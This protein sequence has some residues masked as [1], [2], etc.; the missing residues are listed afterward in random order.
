MILPVASSTSSSHRYVKTVAIIPAYNEEG[1]IGDVVRAV[2]K[3]VDRVI[4]VNDGSR[5]GTAAVAAAEGAIVISHGL[6]CGAGA[7]TMTGIVAARSLGAECAVTIDADGQHN[8][9]DI[10][11]LLA[12]VLRGETDITI[13][14]RFLRANTIPFIRRVFNAIGN[15]LTLITTGMY[16]SDSQSGF[17]CLGPAALRTI[18]LHLNGFEFCTEIIREA[19]RHQ[20]RIAEIPIRVTYSEYTLAKGQSFAGGVRTACKIL[21]RTFLR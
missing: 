10:P 15:I 9:E 14:S 13:G 11:A 4:V 18:E 6:N 1:R 7:A 3:V 12:P 21:L 17:K 19:K 16:V 2:G 5:D 8:P 20:W